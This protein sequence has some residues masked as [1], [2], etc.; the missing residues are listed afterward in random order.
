ES[1]EDSAREVVQMY[2]MGSPPMR[3]VFKG[4]IRPLVVFS[5]QDVDLAQ[6]APTWR[7]RFLDT[8]LMSVDARY[9]RQWRQ[10]QHV[11]L[12]RNHALK[13]P[14]LWETADS[15]AP[16]LQE[17]GWYL[18]Q[19][20]DW[21]L[22]RLVPRAQDIHDR[23]SGGEHLELHHVYGGSSEAVASEAVYQTIWQRRQ[24][25]ER[26]RGMTLVGPHRDDMVLLLNGHPATH[27]ASQG[28]MRTIALSLKL[29]SYAVLRDC[30]GHD[31]LVLLDDVLSELDD[32]RRRALLQLMTQA[33]QQTLVTDTEARAYENLSAWIY[34]VKAG[35]IDRNA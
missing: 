23:L 29:A 30:L 17:S 3:K 15:F 27:Y 6:G 32:T 8:L 31:P 28:Q 24:A 35:E 18:W 25:D 7:R 11:L 19:R 20:R 22:K 34:R 2:R 9:L 16:L 10:Y 26:Q 12:Q 4:T 14:K 5:P 13:E 33:H 1:G 21:L